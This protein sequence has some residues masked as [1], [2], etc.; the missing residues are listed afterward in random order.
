MLQFVNNL[1]DH[2]LR[3]LHFQLMEVE[4]VFH[5]IPGCL[6]AVPANTKVKKR[7]VTRELPAKCDLTVYGTSPQGAKRDHSRLSL[8]QWSTC[9]L[10]VNEY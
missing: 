3:A 7:F 6:L 10:Q 5:S 8:E 9:R 2:W 4:L 1:T